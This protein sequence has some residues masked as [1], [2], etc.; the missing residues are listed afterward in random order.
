MAA[1]AKGNTL[2]LIMPKGSSTSIV[3]TLGPSAKF[4]SSDTILSAGRLTT[5]KLVSYIRDYSRLRDELLHTI[6][7]LGMSRSAR[8][9]STQPSEYAIYLGRARDELDEK[10]AAYQEIQ[11]RIEMLEKQI[12]E[13][14]K[15]ASRIQ[16]VIQA[17]FSSTDLAFGKGEFNRVLG[18]IPARKLADAQRAL[19][20]LLGGQAVLATG[21]RVGDQVYVLLASPEEKMQQA[22]QTLLLYDFAPSEIA[23][24]DEPDLNTAKTILETKIKKMAS[25]LDQARMEL[26]Q[27]QA[28]ASESLNRLADGVQDSLMQMQAVLKLG[29]GAPASKVFAWLTKPPTPRTLSSLS[30]Q[31]VL[32]ETE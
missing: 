4:E 22:T 2:R 29:E 13:A 21:N 26:K 31:G 24:L 20:K 5:D 12:E 1:T 8:T 14:K 6:R 27:F 32:Y 28:H 17:G 15:Q 18:R 11:S 16:E 7:Q 25:D 23:K 3:S 10:K 30:S 19:E 9:A